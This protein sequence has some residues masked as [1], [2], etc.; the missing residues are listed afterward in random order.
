MNHTIV[1]KPTNILRPLRCLGYRCFNT[2]AFER[3]QYDLSSPENN[4]LACMKDIMDNG[5]LVP[6]RTGIRTI[7]KFNKVLSYPISC[8]GIPH[9]VSKIKWDEVKYRFPMVTT[10]K[11]FVRGAITELLWMLRGETD[12]KVLE[13]DGINIWNK[14]SSA[15]F[16]KNRGLDYLPGELGPVYG[17][18][19]VNWGGEWRSKKDTDKQLSKGINQITNIVDMLVNSPTERRIILQAW[20]VAD[21]NKMALPPCHMTY[22]FDVG[23]FNDKI[24]HLNC[25]VIL[26]S[27]D[28]F[29]GH[30][31]NVVGAATLTIL[32]SQLANMVPGS[33]DLVINNAHIYE[34]HIEAVQQQIIRSP[35][36]YPILT[37]KDWV[38]K[39]PLTDPSYSE[40]AYQHLTRLKYTDFNIENYISWNAIKAEMAA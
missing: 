24:R 6:N 22:I 18:Q 9:D 2:E 21:L 29:L 32:L 36:K 12:A 16:L 40:Q 34:N 20:N 30:P 19:W 11:L 1:L 27:N 33:V 7:K 8:F 13:K 3:L 10:K 4:Y 14:N 17:H 28:M 23:G 25:Q 26:R 5:E 37:I 15:E 35:Y 31:F 39:I 38:P